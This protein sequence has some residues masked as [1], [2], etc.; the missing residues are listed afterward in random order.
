MIGILFLGLLIGMQHAMEAD[1]VAAVASIASRETSIRRIVR[2]GTT[3][4]IG[5]ALTFL[6]I[7][8]GVLWAG[9]EI[10]AELSSWLEMMVGLLL[11]GLG[12][13]VIIRLIRERIHFHHHRHRDGTTHVHAHSHVRSLPH[14]EM[15]AHEHRHSRGSAI[16][17]LLIGMTHGVA[18]SAALVVLAISSTSGLAFGLVYI[19]LFCVGSII[20][21]VLLSAVIAVPLSYAAKG[22]TWTHW[23]MNGGVGSTTMGIG[24]VIVVR[25]IIA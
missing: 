11:I 3:W 12:G 13:H 22:L 7:A 14:Q 10:G 19:S 25:H 9:L 21:M 4:G 5:H 6:P 24:I 15:A 23:L 20:G 2:H 8:G 18:G 1:H 17:P 16:G